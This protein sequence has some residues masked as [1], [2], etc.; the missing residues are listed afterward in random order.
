M[1]LKEIRR[2]KL[3]GDSLLIA[4]LYFLLSTPKWGLGF[5]IVT[6]GLLLSNIFLRD[7]LPKENQFGGTF[8]KKEDNWLEFIIE[9]V[10]IFGIAWLL[11]KIS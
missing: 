5:Y 6:F 8:L 11:I 7:M 1:T 4:Y 3:V 2:I 10:A 9:C